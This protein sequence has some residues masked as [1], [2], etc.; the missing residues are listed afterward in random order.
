MKIP[1]ELMTFLLCFEL[2]KEGNIFLA[3]KTENVSKCYFFVKVK[4]KVVEGLG[5]I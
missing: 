1:Y 2:F 3:G 4:T 5:T